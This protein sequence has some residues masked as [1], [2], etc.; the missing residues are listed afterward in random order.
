MF[1]K[2][3]SASYNSN[4]IVVNNWW[5]LNG[6]SEAKLYLNGNCVDTNSQYIVSGNTPI[7]RGGIQGPEGQQHVVEA[8]AKSGLFSVKMKICVDGV[9][10]GGD[11]F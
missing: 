11:R 9:Q 6:R 1:N 3:W 8:F 4:Q 7:L 5:N 2:E 10:I